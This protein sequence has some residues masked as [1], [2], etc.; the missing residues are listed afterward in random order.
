MFG[1]CLCHNPE[2][3]CYSSPLC[4]KCKEIQKIISIYGVDDLLKA[5]RYI[6]V[7]GE[8]PIKNRTE[9]EHKINQK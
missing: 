4:S 2:E 6:Y 9:V 8:E 1:C 3:Y 7:R 5:V